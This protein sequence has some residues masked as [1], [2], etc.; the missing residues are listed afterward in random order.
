V[1]V[2]WGGVIPPTQLG[3]MTPPLQK[4]LFVIHGVGGVGKSSLLKMFRLHS[5]NVNVPVALA[6]GDDSKS[7]LDVLTR[8]TEDLKADGVAFPAFGKTFEH[9]RA[10]QAKVDTEAQKSR[11]KMADLAGKAAGKTA[12]TAAAT[13]VGAALGSVIPGIG[14]IAGAIG[15]IG[16]EALVDWMRGFL[17]KPDIDLLLDP[18]KKLTDDFLDDLGKIAEKKRIVLMLDTFEQMTALEDWA[19]DVAQRVG[20]ISNLPVGQVGN[21]SYGVLLV[22]AGRA[23]PNWGRAWSGWMANA[24]VEELKPMSEDVMRE[25]IRRYYATMR[26]GEPNPTQVDAIIRFARG[27]PMVVTSAVQ[28]WVKYGVEDFQSV[29]AEIVANLVDRLMEGVPSALIPALEAAAI[30]RWFDQPIL[31]AVTGLADVRDVYNELRRFPFVR[32]RVEGLA[33]HDAVREIMDE[34]LRAQDSERH[35]ELHERAAAYF[36]KRL[37]KVTGEESERLGLERL[38][39]RVRADEEAGIKLFQEMAEELTRYRLVNRLRALLNDAN[40]YLLE[41]ENSRLWRE[42]YNAR[43]AHLGMRLEDARQ[44]YLDIDKTVGIESRLRAYALCDLADVIYRMD[45][46]DS[47]ADRE[48]LIRKLE[49]SLSIVRTDAKLSSSYSYL[50]N[51]YFRGGQW[52]KAIPMIEKRINF[53]RQSQDWFGLTEALGHLRGIYAMMGAWRH[54]ID[55]TNTALAFIEKEG[56]LSSR[57]LRARL[58]RE[59]AWLQAWTGKY[60]QSEK[61]TNEVL[62][63][64]TEIGDSYSRAA[65]IRDLAY[66]IGLQE[67]FDEAASMF[68][69]AYYLHRDLNLRIGVVYGF[70][71]G[72]LTKQGIWEKA[73]QSLQNSLSAKQIA[74]DIIGISEIIEWLGELYEVRSDLPKAESHYLQVLDHKAIGRQNYQCAALTGLVRVKHAQGDYAAIPPLLAEAEQLAQQYEYNDHLASL[75]LT[76]GMTTDVMGLNGQ[77]ASHPSVESNQSVVI[78]FFKQAMIYALR[79]N[80]FLLDEVLSGRPQGTPLR[81]II[82]YCLERGQEGREILM[83]L[84]DWWKTGINDI[85]TPRPDTISPIPEAI[86]LLE[87]ERIAREREP[88]DGSPQKNVME[89]IE[90]VL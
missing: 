19:R 71:G 85:G 4:R 79:Y 44:V 57:T 78:G 23:L 81:P 36:E 27:L 25:L 66:I 16:A 55:T 87:A 59:A 73:E 11:G 70:E 72:I 67:K 49:T 86:A 88:G 69:D 80:R 5:K 64:T 24:Q 13:A 12:E 39:H 29:K 10:I 77:N 17:T 3:G 38:Y 54:A 14:T 45:K 20:Q 6:S 2:G 1:L 83:A 84:R 8:W 41:R 15:G 61:E 18:T 22:I 74:R 42:Y 52:Q 51:V 56:N 89:Q 28:L 76:Q 82:P 43:I 68:V 62:S 35:C 21:L 47:E 65:T 48:G 33:L 32:T 31:R 53:A 75:R 9:Y 7:A 63:Y 90:G 34:N 26:G 37:E 30:V 40:T 50:A 58:F 60:K 46:L